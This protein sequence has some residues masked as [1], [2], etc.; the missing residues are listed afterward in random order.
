MSLTHKTGYYSSVA[1]SPADCTLCCEATSQAVLE[2]FHIDCGV[3]GDVLHWWLD[4]WYPYGQ[5][6]TASDAR[7]TIDYAVRMNGMNE[8]PK[9]VTQKQCFPLCRKSDGRQSDGVR[10]QVRQVRG[11]IP[12]YRF[13]FCTAPVQLIKIKRYCV[14]NFEAN[15]FYYVDCAPIWKVRLASHTLHSCI[16]CLF[17]KFTSHSLMSMASSVWLQY[18]MVNQRQGTD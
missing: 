13:R 12:T 3:L 9:K 16:L 5:T 7:N 1:R 2:N 10:E 8:T 6:E 4:T 15:V 18:Y 17:Q 14:G 11:S